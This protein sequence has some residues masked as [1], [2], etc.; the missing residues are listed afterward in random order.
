MQ[1]D[2]IFFESAH[3]A[4]VVATI[5]ERLLA[6]AELTAK[7]HLPGEAKDEHVAVVS[8]PVGVAEGVYG[9][10]ALCN[11]IGGGIVIKLR[12]YNNHILKHLIETNDKG[13]PFH[14]PVIIEFFLIG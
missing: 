11:H 10:E 6:F 3:H 8:R 13:N 1:C 14:C 7:V 4:V 12:K 5:V 9:A 2:K